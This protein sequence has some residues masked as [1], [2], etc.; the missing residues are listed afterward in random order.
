MIDTSKIFDKVETIACVCAEASTGQKVER[1]DIKEKTVRPSFVIFLAK[2]LTMMTAHDCYGIPYKK[3]AK[4]M[5]MNIISV[6]NAV[7]KA[8]ERRFF[9]P[10]YKHCH[11]LMQTRL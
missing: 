4:H 7:R 3:I 10:V 5:D 6:M 9:D 8:R 1:T 2:S 11:E